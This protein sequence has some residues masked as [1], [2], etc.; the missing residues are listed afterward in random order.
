LNYICKLHWIS[1]GGED[2]ASNGSPVFLGD[3][4]MFHCPTTGS[5]LASHD[6]VMGREARLVPK[7]RMGL[8]EGNLLLI[9]V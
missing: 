2:I 9:Y 1:K 5:L 8:S 7:E 3:V 6:G 4:I